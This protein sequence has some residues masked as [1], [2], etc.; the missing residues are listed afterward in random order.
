MDKGFSKICECK[1]CN[2]YCKIPEGRVGICGIRENKNGKLELLVYGK[3]CAVNIDPIEKKPLF[4]FMPG[5]KIFSIGTF[6]CNFGCEFCQNY[7]ISQCTREAKGDM[8]RIHAICETDD[9]WMPKRITEY[10]MNE[11]IPS[12]A[13]TYNE[14]AV[15][16]EYAFDTAKLSHSR[17]LKN[18]FV[19]NGFNSKESLAK[20]KPYLDAINIDLKSFRS[21]F[22]R[23]ICHAKIEPVLEN[24]KRCYEMGIWLEVTTLIIPGYND[25]DEELRNI[26]KFIRGISQDIPWHVSAFYPCYKLLDARRATAS[27]LIRAYEI[28]KKAGLNYV[29]TG[30]IPGMMH[31]STYCPKCGETLIERDNM[32]VLS[33]KISGGGCPK[34]NHKIVGIW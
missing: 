32:R 1:A 19:S 17:G 13:Y 21:E 30:N 14:P 9:V 28:G 22:Y 34:C 5:S 31:E 7:D 27:D 25:S 2:F 18:V 26:A 15:F 8:E 4:H 23:D 20:I 6:G 11:G 10:C 24:I 16:F 3:P 33:N 12:V 29:Y